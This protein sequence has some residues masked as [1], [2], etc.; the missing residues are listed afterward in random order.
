MILSAFQVQT[1]A[2]GFVPCWWPSTSMC[3]AEDLAK[4]LSVRTDQRYPN[5]FWV[6]DGD[7]AIGKWFKGLRYAPD[8]LI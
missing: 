1:S 8:Q 4:Q 6:V 7:K 2:P 3:I 5:P